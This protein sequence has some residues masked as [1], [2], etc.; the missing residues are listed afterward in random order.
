MSSHTTRHPTTTAHGFPE[1]SSS[2][3]KARDSLSANGTLLVGERVC[4]RWRD[5]QYHSPTR[6]PFAKRFRCRWPQASDHLSEDENN[7][8]R[9]QRN[10]GSTIKR[11]DAMTVKR[12]DTG[13]AGRR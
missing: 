11:H 6:A 7:T 3:W 1:R 12:D 2:C 9:E 10:E 8:T 4:R 13:A 5:V